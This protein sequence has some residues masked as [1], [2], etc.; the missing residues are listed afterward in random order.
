MTV[1]TFPLTHDFSVDEDLDN[2]NIEST[3]K[4]TRLPFSMLLG[5]KILRS[6]EINDISSSV[7][8]SIFESMALDVDTF[9]NAEPVDENE[10]LFDDHFRP[11]PKSK[12]II[13]VKIQYRGKAK[14][15]CRVDEY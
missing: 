5:E 11:I 3:H 1:A 8:I 7:P 14:I 9:G 4:R 15:N 2:E 6:K 12:S 10:I 13:K